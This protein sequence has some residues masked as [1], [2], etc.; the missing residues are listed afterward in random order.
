MQVQL[1][2][3]FSLLSV[4]SYRVP[5]VLIVA[6]SKTHVTIPHCA[7]SWASGL[8]TQGGNTATCQTR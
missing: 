8:D 4:N 5:G 2:V 7:N 1:L 6:C 3:L